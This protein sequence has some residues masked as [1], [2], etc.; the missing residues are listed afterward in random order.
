MISG[1]LMSSSNLRPKWWQLYLTFPLLIALFVAENRLKISARG[2][3]AVQI[4]IVLLIFGLIHLWIKANSSAL[5][6]MDQEQYS[7][8]FT[9]IRIPSDQLSDLDV[10]EGSRFALPL[11]EI[12]GV[13]SDTFDVEHIDSE[14]FPDYEASQELIK[15]KE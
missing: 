9:V 7:G 10:E 8:R 12:K 15:E 1:E 2:H 13:L 14:A 5:S 6:R 11:S 3:Q 4:V